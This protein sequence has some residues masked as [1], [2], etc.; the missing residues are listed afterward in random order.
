MWVLLFR[1]FCLLSV[2]AG[3]GHRVFDDALKS[4]VSGHL[5]FIYRSQVDAGEPP[6]Q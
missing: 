6:Q 1:K 4:Q 5:A 2:S 3:N